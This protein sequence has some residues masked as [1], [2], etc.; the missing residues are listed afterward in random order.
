MKERERG[1]VVAGK[2]YLVRKAGVW[3]PPPLPPYFDY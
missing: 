3:N 2:W 1:A